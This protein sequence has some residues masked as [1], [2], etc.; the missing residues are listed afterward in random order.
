[1]DAVAAVAAVGHS[2]S[3]ILI[4][5]GGEEDVL[6]R[7][8]TGLAGLGGLVVGIVAGADV[9]DGALLVLFDEFVS[10]VVAVMGVVVGLAVF[11]VLDEES[12]FEVADGPPI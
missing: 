10:N 1:V 2:S 6:A 7:F 12:E 4:G 9:V 3:S 5:A 8:H 11:T